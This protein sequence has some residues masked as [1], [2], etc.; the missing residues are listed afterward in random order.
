LDWQES[1]LTR[2]KMRCPSKST[3]YPEVFRPKQ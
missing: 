2:V 3:C 1:I